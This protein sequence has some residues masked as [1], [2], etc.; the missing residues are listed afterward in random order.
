MEGPRKG[1][2]LTF[3]FHY[4]KDRDPHPV[5]HFLSTL[6]KSPSLELLW[7]LH[8][9]PFP[10]FPT[11]SF[12]PSHLHIRRT[13]KFGKPPFSQQKKISQKTQKVHT[14]RF[15]QKLVDLYFFCNKKE[16]QKLP[17]HR[18]YPPLSLGKVSWMLCLLAFCFCY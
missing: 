10:S 4:E 14:F 6:L 16:N 15:L 1:K 7:H 17:V 11:Q 12:Y 13:R 9:H 3:S 2:G 8:T 18:S 5:M